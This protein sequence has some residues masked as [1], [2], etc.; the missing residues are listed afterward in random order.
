MRLSLFIPLIS[1]VFADDDPLASEGDEAAPYPYGTQYGTKPPGYGSQAGYGGKH[2]YGSQAG[3]G[4]K[5]GCGSQIGYGGK[6][7]YGSQIGYGGKPPGYAQGP[8]Y[9]SQSS[10]GYGTKPPGY[11]GGGGPGYGEGPAAPT[12]PV[13]PEVLPKGAEGFKL[14]QGGTASPLQFSIALPSSEGAAD[15]IGL[16]VSSKGGHVVTLL[17]RIDSQERAL[18]GALSVLETECSI[19]FS[20][21]SFLLAIDRSPNLTYNLGVQITA[22]G[23]QG[24]LYFTDHYGIPP[25]SNKANVTLTPIARETYS[26]DGNWKFAFLCKGCLS[27]NRDESGFSSATMGQPAEFGF[28]Y[29]SP[30]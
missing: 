25:I 14:I 18:V 11:G 4:G 28:A 22:S 30:Y 6:P 12:V 21:V 27:V 16:L 9:S 3:Y 5:P 15:F 2:G 17:T 26:K 19:S 29:V 23:P 20:L 8:G 1:V 10:P 7:G 24:A 13:V